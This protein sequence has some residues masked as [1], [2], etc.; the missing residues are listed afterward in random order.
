[1]KSRLDKVAREDITPERLATVE[2]IRAKFRTPEAKAEE[3]RVREE[4]RL[5]FPPA[6]IDAELCAVVAA[7]CA[8]RER[9]G[10]SLTDA[11]ERA[12]SRGA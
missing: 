2:S 4:V 10:L 3:Q 5:E 6:T 12:G 9:Q 1:M 11:A 8:E 7:L